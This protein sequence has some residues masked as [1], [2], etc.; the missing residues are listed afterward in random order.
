[1]KQEILDEVDRLHRVVDARVSVLTRRHIKRLQC[2]RGCSGC[3]Q[4]ELTVFEVEAAL[5]TTRHAAVLQQEPHPE[6][7]CAFLDADGA[8]R[9]YADRPYVCRT[10]GLPLRWIEQVLADDG[11]MEVFEYRDICHL[12]DVDPPL[13]I[14]EAED[15]WTIGPVEERLCELQEE[16]GAQKRVGLRG[17]FSIL[18]A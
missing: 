5:I 3:C 4:D 14:L 18:T 10:Q 15:F 8:C 2:Q 1:M 12:N 9:I 6:G 17:L 16:C 11:V 13:E 7:A